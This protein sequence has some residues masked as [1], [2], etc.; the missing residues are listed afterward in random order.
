MICTNCIKKDVCKHYIYLKEYDGLIL[1]DCNYKQL[2]IGSIVKNNYGSY[3]S[4][5]ALLSDRKDISDKIQ[6]INN[7]KLTEEEKNKNFKVVTTPSKLI[8][9]PSCGADIYPED[10]TTCDSCGKDACPACSTQS[11]DCNKE[12]FTNMCDEC[13]SNYNKDYN[14]NVVDWSD[15]VGTN[16][17]SN[18]PLN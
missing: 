13:W 6:E 7:S 17:E 4:S 10:L 1:S 3:E 18:R 9:C 15:Y 12:K 16:P 2:N 5:T 8:E 11:Y 14:A